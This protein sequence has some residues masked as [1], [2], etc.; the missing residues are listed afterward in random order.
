MSTQTIDNVKVAQL[1]TGLAQKSSSEGLDTYCPHPKQ[2]PFHRS[3]AREKWFFTGNRFGKTWACLCNLVWWI[4]KTH[5]CFTPVKDRYEKDFEFWNRFWTR[6]YWQNVPDALKPMPEDW[7]YIRPP[8]GTM[9]ARIM[10][11][12]T[13]VID[14]TI[15]GDTLKKLIPLR[16]LKGGSWSQAYQKQQHMINMADGSHIQIKTYKQGQLDLQSL[17]GAALHYLHFDEEPTTRDIYDE[18][19]IRLATTGGPITGCITPIKSQQWVYSDIYEASAE[20]PDLDVFGGKFNDNPFISE[21][22]QI[23][24]AERLKSD[25]DKAAAR[26]EGKFVWLR[27]RVFAEYGD[28]H[29]IDPPKEDFLRKLQITIVIDPHDSKPTYVNGIAWDIN[30]PGDKPDVIVFKELLIKGNVDHVCQAIKAEFAGFKIANILIDRSAHR[31]SQLVNQSNR[32]DTILEMFRLPHN[33]GNKI[34]PVGGDPQGRREIIHQYLAEDVGVGAP[35]L[36][37]SKECTATNFQMRNH[38]YKSNLPSGEERATE[39]VIKLNDDTV[40]NI[41]N[42]LLVG[43]PIINIRRTNAQPKRS[44]GGYQEQAQA[45]GWGNQRMV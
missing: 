16:Y 17:A 5:P 38:H 8:S 1:L 44:W 27:G 31:K 12:D 18:C 30:A 40:D 26:M 28:R 13:D 25:P 14:T 29:W 2:E 6:S 36:F 15:I 32:P 34:N 23:S 10:C 43:P 39:Q 37:V 45:M 21:E 33:F 22:E 11:Q 20:R 4:T 42:A 41:G 7:P 35:H 9:R 3:S 24:M 19:T